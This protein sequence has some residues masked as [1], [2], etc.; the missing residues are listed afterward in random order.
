MTEAEVKFEVNL[1]PTVNGSVCLGVGLPSG[2]HDQLQLTAVEMSFSYGRQS[3]DQVVLVSGSPL[4]PMT[5]FYA[6]PFFS[7]NCFVVLPVERPL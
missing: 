6:Y 3:V 1:R 5:R 7:D 2:A 4:G